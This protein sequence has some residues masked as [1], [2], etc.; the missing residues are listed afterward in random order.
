MQGRAEKILTAL[1]MMSGTSMDGIDLAVV[2]SDG[3]GFVERGPERHFPYLTA[4]RGRLE[5]ALETAKSITSRDERPGDLEELERDL[6]RKH[7]EAF[8]EFCRLE[9]IQPGGIDV[10]GFHGQTVLHRPR[11]GLTVQLGDGRQLA[12]ETGC[13]V[14]F[15]MR[16][17]DMAHGGQGAPLVPVYHA[18][19][20]A[21]QETVTRPA[22]FVNIGGISN[23]TYVGPDGALS[24]F[25]CGPGNALI[26]QWMQTEAGIPYDA[27]GAI[28]S[29]GGVILQVLE[30][31]MSDSFFEEPVPKSLDRNDFSPLEPGSL[32]LADGARTLAMV[33]AKSIYRSTEHLPLKPAT[34]V[35]CGGGRL[36]RNIRA[37][38]ARQA[39]PDKATVIAAEEAGFNG[40]SMEAEAWAYLAIR[41]LKGLP[42]TFP[43]TTGCREPVTGGILAK[44]GK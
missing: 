37:D 26:D 12:S 5:Q 40:D 23:I 34:W 38:L 25:D 4:F 8:H 31:Y 36:N 19:L 44:P 20:A 24:A 28:G 22:A 6:T 21:A 11:C 3:E 42:L 30:H 33:T 1:G 17:N 41:S 18:A 27:G 35:L 14:V 15:D 10:I 32:P 29:E 9:S 13:D 2:R 7:A 16:A 43:G 39:E